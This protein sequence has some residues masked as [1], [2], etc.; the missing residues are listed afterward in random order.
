MSREPVNAVAHNPWRLAPP[1]RRTDRGHSP[2][3]PPRLSL[4]GQTLLLRHREAKDSLSPVDVLAA[5]AGFLLVRFREGEAV[6]TWLPP[7]QILELRPLDAPPPT[8]LVP[9][10][11]TE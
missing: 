11:A 1:E 5:E 2:H 8:V 9:D 7:H 4:V 10:V 3:D 6:T